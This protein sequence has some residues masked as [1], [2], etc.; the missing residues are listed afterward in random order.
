MNYKE[1]INQTAE[2]LSPEFAVIE[3]LE[4]SPEVLHIAVHYGEDSYIVAD[5]ILERYFDIHLDCKDY[6]LKSFDNKNKSFLDNINIESC[7]VCYT[8]RKPGNDCCHECGGKY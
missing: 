1:A 6:K 3:K 8:A 4:Q 7:D 2:M 5:D